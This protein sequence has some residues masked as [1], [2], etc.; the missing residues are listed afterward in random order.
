MFLQV[1]APELLAR[2]PNP[3]SLLPG[4][5][6]DLEDANRRIDNPKIILDLDVFLKRDS[7]PGAEISILFT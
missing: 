1:S 6:V 2:S 5:R 3:G 4:G 7:E